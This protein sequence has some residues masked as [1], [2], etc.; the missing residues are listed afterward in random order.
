MFPLN[1]THFI[2][3][4]ILSRMC[5]FGQR[6]TSWERHLSYEEGILC[7]YANQIDVNPSTNYNSIENSKIIEWISWESGLN[8]NQVNHYVFINIQKLTDHSSSKKYIIPPKYYMQM[9][10]IGIQIPS[11]KELLV[12]WIKGEISSVD[13]EWIFQS[14]IKWLF[15]RY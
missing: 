15:T 14:R 11:M 7:V 1:E 5:S 3:I 9:K 2:L 13:N 8:I 12:Y 4:D 6:P 10:F